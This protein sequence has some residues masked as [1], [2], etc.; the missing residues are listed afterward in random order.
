[1][2]GVVYPLVRLGR[3]AVV[4]STVQATTHSAPLATVA[5]VATDL[6][7]IVLDARPFLRGGLALLVAALFLPWW[8]E[9][10]WNAFSHGARGRPY[11]VELA[12]LVVVL[13]GITC[14]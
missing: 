2:L 12:A 6:T 1:M 7:S 10:Y 9:S 14:A 13:V 8:Y 5:A 11:A 3:A 4:G